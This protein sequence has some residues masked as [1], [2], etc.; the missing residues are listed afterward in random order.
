MVALGLV[1]NNEKWGRPDRVGAGWADCAV[2]EKKGYAPATHV[3]T[4][5]VSS[6]RRSGVGGT[7]KSREE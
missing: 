1:A 3:R 5:V 6:Q 7:P 4:V 2:Q